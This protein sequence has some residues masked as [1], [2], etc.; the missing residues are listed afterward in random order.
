MALESMVFKTNIILIFINAVILVMATVPAD[1]P[2]FQS[3]GVIP[4]MSWLPGD[5]NVSDI[6]ASSTVISTSNRTGFIGK[7]A[8]VL[9]LIPVFGDFLASSFSAIASVY[10]IVLYM[11]FGYA[12]LLM[13][14]GLP[15]QLV[16]IFLAPIA[17]IQLYGAFIILRTL[18]GVLRGVI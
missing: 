8:D 9:Q 17:A 11:F 3:A 7:T 2:M 13:A 5:I 1:Q 12:M 10:S 4:E 15:T 14:I 6:N 18:I 16:F